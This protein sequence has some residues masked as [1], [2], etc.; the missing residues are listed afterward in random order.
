MKFSTILAL[1][2]SAKILP[3]MAWPGMK[4][5][6]A[7]LEHKLAARQDEVG[8]GDGTDVEDSDELIG[9]LVTVGAVTDVAQQIQGVITGSIDGF[10]SEAY[11]TTVPAKKSAACAA[12]TCCIWSYIAA[13]MK[14]KFSGSSGRCNGFAR[15]AVRM[16]FHDAGAWSK[17]STNGG[18][19]GS[20]ILA[21][22]ISRAENNG[23]Q[24]IV[25]WTTSL[26]SKYK[27]YGVGMADMIQMAATVATVVCPL[28]PRIRSYVGRIDNSAPAPDG[29]L[30]DVNADAETLIQL[31]ADKTIKT[32]G[33]TALIGAH[34]TSQQRFVNT[35]RAFDPQDSTPGIWDVNF[36]NQ[37]LQ[38]ASAIPKRV[39][40]F[41][42]DVVLSQ[43]PVVATEW[44]KFVTD[45]SDW[46]ED[47]SRE[48]VRLSLLGV[49]N[50]NNLIE[51]TKVLPAA[52][53]TY[54]PPDKA[55]ILKWL[56]GQFPKLGKFLDSA[57]KLNSTLLKSLGY[58]P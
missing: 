50:I 26:Y 22:E 16:G 41:N 5:I 28:G 2:A 42:S 8:D 51:C 48:Y 47:F 3:A 32:H 23:L 20:L 39:F 52:K 25:S 1:Y 33:L 43:H 7:E 37:T 49:N 29:L 27:T 4:N 40:K 11:T 35:S 34:S 10:S 46:N 55:I 57:D 15:A 13:D 38:P 21:G 24:D 54:T 14:K 56:A 12:D 19:D 31:F 18:A 45:Q 58:T 17:T 36:Y 53:T 44:N 6:M 9:D 30:P